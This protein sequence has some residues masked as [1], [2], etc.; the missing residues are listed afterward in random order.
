MVCFLIINSFNFNVF[1]IGTYLL[2]YLRF[3]NAATKDLLLMMGRQ[4]VELMD[5]LVNLWTLYQECHRL[6]IVEF[7]FYRYFLQYSIFLDL[8]LRQI[9]TS[10]T[11]K[12]NLTIK[13]IKFQ[14]CP[15]ISCLVRK[16]LISDWQGSPFGPFLLQQLRV[17]Q[18]TLKNQGCIIIGTKTTFETWISWKYACPSFS[19][20]GCYI[21]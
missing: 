13:L 7:S 12:P 19:L 16:V 14:I 6:H 10:P 5:T 20:T 8:I 2:R 18:V 9:S 11:N 15:A 3:F 21:I 4:S 17:T 1:Q